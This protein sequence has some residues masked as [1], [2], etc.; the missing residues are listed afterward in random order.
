MKL[1]TLTART[2]TEPAERLRRFWLAPR[3]WR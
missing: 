1:T 3:C 2:T